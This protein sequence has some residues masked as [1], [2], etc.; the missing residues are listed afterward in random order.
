MDSDTE[1][2]SNL[3]KTIITIYLLH[4]STFSSQ[5]VFKL[6]LATNRYI[7]SFY[8]VQYTMFENKLLQYNVQE[9]VTY[10]TKRK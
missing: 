1:D 2:N 6:L 7:N 5:V 10:V 3:V 9:F 8:S 4:S